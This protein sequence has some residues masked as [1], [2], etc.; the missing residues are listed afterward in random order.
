MRKPPAPVSNVA[1]VSL[2]LEVVDRDRPG[3]AARDVEQA[4]PDLQADGRLAR[5]GV[6]E[7][8]DGVALERAAIDVAAG[9][10][11]DEEGPGLLVEGDALGIAAGMGLQ[12]EHTLL[13]AVV[14]AVVMTAAG[15]RH[16]GADGESEHGDERDQ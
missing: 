15:G 16:G 2:V 7:R 6:D 9:D 10:D 13:R 3:H 8:L 1:T 12:R 4:A 5:R 11:A 14:V